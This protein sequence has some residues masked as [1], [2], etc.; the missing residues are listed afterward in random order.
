ML[1][2][3]DD[4]DD[5]VEQYIQM[6]EDICRY[7]MAIIKLH[8]KRIQ[9]SIPKGVKQGGSLL[10]LIHGILGGSTYETAKSRMARDLRLMENT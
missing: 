7:S 9:S 5:D 6:M 8:N 4:D 3:Y 2:I 1:S 10:K